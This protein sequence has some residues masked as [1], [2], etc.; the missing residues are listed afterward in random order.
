M[1][2]ERINS[3]KTTH[4]GRSRP[5]SRCPIPAA[6]SSERIDGCDAANSTSERIGLGTFLPV[7]FQDWNGRKPPVL[8]VTNVRL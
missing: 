2:L 7:N 8:G 5:P 1:V 6:R 4:P 3:M